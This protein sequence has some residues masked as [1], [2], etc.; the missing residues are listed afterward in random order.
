YCFPRQ[1]MNSPARLY[2]HSPCFDGIVSAVLTWDFAESVLK[3]TIGD[4]QPVNYKLRPSWLAD[5]LVDLCAV[6]DFLYHPKAT[7]W[8][9]HHSTAFLSPE[10]KRDFELK[11][12]PYLAYNS[13]ADSCAKLLWD[14]FKRAFRYRNHAYA[15][16]V[17]WASKIDAAKYSSVR[18]AIQGAE[19]ALRINCSLAYGDDDGYSTSLVRH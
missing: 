10:V 3:W 12:G 5:P 17:S 9:D 18:E 7:F 16:L 14:H 11:Q 13:A 19:P 4:L 1:L 2:F 6:V 8:A 15:E